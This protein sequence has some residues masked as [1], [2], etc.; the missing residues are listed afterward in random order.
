M[1]ISIK[2]KFQGSVA[3]PTAVLMGSLL[4]L[5]GISVVLLSA[6]VKRTTSGY[7]QSTQA[8]LNAQPCKEEAIA[9]L[10]YDADYTGT[11]NV[12]F[13]E[14][15]CQAIVSNIGGNPDLKELVVTTTNY[16]SDMELKFQVDVSDYPVV[17]TPL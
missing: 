1:L 15:S 3:L 14:A 4:L 12:T 10:K 11:I 8:R 13:P 7:N 2:K 17:V 16:D 9:R 5:G 6:D